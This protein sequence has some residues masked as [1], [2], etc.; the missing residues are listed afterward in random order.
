MRVFYICSELRDPRQT[1][2]YVPSY[3][4]N[5]SRNR[6]D[7]WGHDV[8]IATG[9]AR[10]NIYWVVQGVINSC[11]G[12]ISPVQ[13]RAT[14]FVIL[15]YI[16]VI[17]MEHVVTSGSRDHLGC[18]IAVLEVTLA[19]YKVCAKESGLTINDETGLNGRDGD[20]AQPVYAAVLNQS[21]SLSR[22]TRKASTR[23]Q[24]AL[25]LA[26]NLPGDAVP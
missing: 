10:P 21:V 9:I 16:R 22:A 18:C 15:W 19:W 8:V 26:R 4:T 5:A 6:H 17:T 12:C 13:R 25:L 2:T 23:E 11:G 14:R 20:R 3:S 1:S 24:Y 7:F